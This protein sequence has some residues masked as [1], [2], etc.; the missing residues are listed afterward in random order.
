MNAVTQS[1]ASLEPLAIGK[2][3]VQFPFP[4]ALV[5]WVNQGMHV[6][7]GQMALLVDRSQVVGILEAV[8][9][10]VLEWS[11]K[12]E[13]AGITGNGYSFSLQEK[14]IAHQ[15]TVNISIG[16]I[17]NFAGNVGSATGGAIVNAHQT[18]GLD[19]SR[20]RQLVDQVEKVLPV[21]ELGVRQEESARELVAGLRAELS[22]P[23]PDQNTV[24]SMLGMLKRAMEGAASKII[25][26]GII[27]NID[28]VL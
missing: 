14:E 28:Q 26:D 4:P 17:G 5:N 13:K 9:T 22:K 10:T 23:A 12:L 25:A 1:I 11:L 20:T 21:A 19:M 24:R 27:S 6:H 2:G 3:T 15:Q 16:S 18:V 7:F 8:R